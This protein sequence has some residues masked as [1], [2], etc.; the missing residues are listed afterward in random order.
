MHLK[1][2]GVSVAPHCERSQTPSGPA[3]SWHWTPDSVHVSGGPPDDKPESQAI[4][5]SSDPS[6]AAQRIMAREPGDVHR[7][8][9]WSIAMGS[10]F[11][12]FTAS[13]RP[14]D[15]RSAASSRAD[16]T[17][18][19]DAV[20]RRAAAEVNRVAPPGGC[21]PSSLRWSETGR[22]GGRRRPRTQ[23]RSRLLVR[24]RR[25]NA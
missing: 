2:G 22:A 9:T 3:G 24:R 1:Q 15:R 21:S 25:G 12:R 23:I 10:G 19:A 18:P 16:R 20:C 8:R 5:P 13:R 17:R 11:T 4:N 6:R 14:T 7:T